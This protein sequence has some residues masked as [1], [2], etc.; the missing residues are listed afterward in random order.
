MTQTAL[1]S[2]ASHMKS[3][4]A[5][6]FNGQVVGTATIQSAGTKEQVVQMNTS[7]LKAGIYLCKLSSNSGQVSTKR[8][9]VLR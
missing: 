4:A 1:D 9:T 7:N 2:F 3:V 6:I 5:L 8:F